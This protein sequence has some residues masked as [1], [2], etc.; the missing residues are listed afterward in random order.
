MEIITA[1]LEMMKEVAEVSETVAETGEGMNVDGLKDTPITELQTIRSDLAGKEHSETGIRYEEK[2]VDLGDGEIYKGV[3]PEFETP[4]E[5]MLDENQYLESDGR[6]F[7][8]A[9]GELQIAISE[10]PELA[11]QFNPEQLEQIASGRTPDGYVWHHSETPG[12]LQLVD[13]EI[14]ELTRHTGGRAI[15]GGGQEFR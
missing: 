4:F 14:H 3:F 6:Q 5:V 11:G 10:N 2:V 15:W 1:T 7:R 8:H 13:K 12:V 9:N